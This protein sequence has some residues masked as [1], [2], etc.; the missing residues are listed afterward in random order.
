MSLYLTPANDA[1]I[2]ENCKTH[3]ITIKLCYNYLMEILVLILSS[4]STALLSLSGGFLLL[5]GNK[6]AKTLRKFGPVIAFFVLL[7]AVFGDLVP[8]ILEDLPPLTL[9]LW[10]I[11]GFALCA[12]LAALMGHFHHHSDV[13]NLKAEDK[14]L[15][16][17]K[18]DA[19][20]ML[21]VDSVH[22]VAD[23]LMLGMSFLAG[24]P[25]GLTTC[26]S[27]VAHEIPQEI[28][29]FAI[30]E[31]SKMRHNKIIRYQILSGLILVP[32]ALLAYFVG[33]F[34]G[35][36]LPVMLSVV[37]GSLLYLAFS[38]LVV[39]FEMLREHQPKQLK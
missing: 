26:L 23:G 21:A 6:F 25:A 20:T 3:F 8:E 5:S 38:E 14:K 4:V 16:K 27:V 39:I 30:M 10:L 12:I 13:Q 2:S 11:L 9:V 1:N 37:A 22:T 32:S 28:G 15:L 34:L 24:I 29:D 31:R 33:N 7:Y 17:S 19:Y 18:S 35:D 36:A